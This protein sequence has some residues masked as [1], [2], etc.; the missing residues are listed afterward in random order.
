MSDSSRAS[1]RSRRSSA[2]GQSSTGRRSGSGTPPKRKRRWL[3][4]T[5]WTFVILGIL[6]IVGLVAAYALVR[7]PQPNDIATAQAS[8]IYYADGETEMARIS[9]INRESVPLSDIPEPVQKAMLSAEDRK[10]YQ[11]NGVSP[12]GIARSVWT[13]VKGGEVQGSG[14]T[15]TQQYV[16]NY[17]LTADRTITRKAKEILIS[18]KIDRQQTKDQIL[19][20]Y[21]NTIYYGRGAY[22]IQTAAQ[23]YYGKDAKDLT[24]SEGAFLASVVNGPGY[25]DPDLGEKQLKNAQ[26]RWTYV[27]DGMVT[28]GWLTPQERA[29]QTFAMP[30][31]Y[32]Q[33]TAT[34]T[35]GYLTQMVKSELENKLKL[36]PQDIDRGGLRIVS[37]IDKAKEEAAI[38]AVQ[39]G[40]PQVTDG[41]PLHAGL[42][43]IVP[44]DGA[45]AAIYGGADYAERQWND[46][47]DATIQAGSTFKI[48][49]LIGALNSGKVNLRSTFDG[50]GPQ[51]FPEFADS[52][53]TTEAQ[54]QGMVSN[55]GNGSF[56]YLDIEDATANS[57]NTIY[58]QLNI[59]GTPQATAKVATDA[60]VT[61]KV[62][63]NYANVFGSDN[64][65]V[66]DMANA[67]ATIAAKGM[68]ATPYIVKSARSADGIFDYTVTPETKRVFAEDTMADVITA[69]RAVVDHGSGSY[70][71]NIGRPAA[72]KTGTTSDNYGAWF[73]G[74]IP[75]LSTAVGIYRGDG[76]LVQANRMND[77]PGVGE[78]TGGSIPVRIWTAYMEQAVNGLDVVDFPAPAY[79]NQDS[80]VPPPATNDPVPTNVPTSEPSDTPSETAAPTPTRTSTPTPT[81]T[82]PVPTPTVTVPTPTIS[83]PTPTISVPIPPTQA[84]SG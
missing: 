46:A 57:V 43:S 53:G 77:I 66:I 28:E 50:S 15:I 6:G 41:A 58:A 11:E 30:I 5:V 76:A 20:N 47:T 33:K 36:T 72:G 62:Q 54:R 78:L 13:A 9:E 67:Y 82:V 59:L 16:K 79:V 26:E 81:P 32:V 14:S 21:F 23:A 18:I 83:I 31:E 56:G 70:A 1:Q 60:G 75:Q 61:T 74:F 40:L 48:F 34:G 7:V 42:A 24:V 84:A 68:H 8:I 45:I 27:L 19:E 10:F 71:Q 63:T 4:R 55:F 29:A 38:A 39:D 25:Y 51:A 22:G 73:D 17:F 3:R 35:T 2:S 69:M 52:T 65:R 37:T 64:V 80:Y 12:T 44:G 49:S